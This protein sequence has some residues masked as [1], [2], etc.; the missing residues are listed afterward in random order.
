[1]NFK[2]RLDFL[3]EALFEIPKHVYKDIFSYYEELV[4]KA[5]GGTYTKAYKKDFPQKI[6]PLDFSGTRYEFLN[7]LSPRP[8]IQVEFTLAEWNPWM[9]EHDKEE[10]NL[11]IKYNRARIQLGLKNFKETGVWVLE[12]EILHA[13]QYL[14]K[15]YKAVKTIE[16]ITGVKF[17]N[18]KS[19]ENEFYDVVMAQGGEIGGV[20]NTKIIKHWLATVDTEGRFLP[21]REVRV[22]HGARPVEFYPNLLM[23]VR[24]MQEAYTRKVKS[25]DDF[26]KDTYTNRD[27]FFKEVY[28]DYLNRLKSDPYLATPHNTF[29]TY[30]VV[31]PIK[32]LLS[33]KLI[34]QEFYKKVLKIA[35]NAFVN[36]DME[37]FDID[38]LRSKEEEFR[39]LSR[40]NNLKRTVSDIKGG[41][42]KK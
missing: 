22:E 17:D 25:G 31:V 27:N 12:H 7:K 18:K 3:S 15:K 38:Y 8:S 32:V 16:D 39:K 28:Q 11:I 5:Y 2:K 19:L 24:K 4:K 36:G 6:F 1:M 26:K 23:F 10:T 41:K 34:G 29:E 30:G 9:M 40:I 37:N 20:P 35:Y 13:I 33:A 42:Y 14:I 21:N